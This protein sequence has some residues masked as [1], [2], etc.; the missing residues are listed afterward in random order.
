MRFLTLNEVLELYFQ[1]MERSGGGV[2]IH[3]LGAWS[4]PSPS[5]V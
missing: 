2:G 5:L 4:Q 1:I 3:D